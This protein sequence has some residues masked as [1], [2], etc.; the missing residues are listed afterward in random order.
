M[1][2]STVALGGLPL[3][4]QNNPKAPVFEG[5]NW[6]YGFALV[7]VTV[8]AYSPVWRAGFIWD[9]D[10]NV[11]AN[12]MLS[13]P[14]GFKQ[15]WSST[16]SPQYY[17]MVFTLF[18]A[19]HALWGNSPAGYH[20]VNVLVHAL[21]ALLFWRV[22]K[23]LEVPGSWLAALIFAL[24]PA[25]IESVAWV[26]ELKNTLA[27]C[28]F[29][30]SLLFF[31]QFDE[32]N[33]SG[34]AASRR[35]LHYFLCVSFFIL[36]ILSKTAIAPLPVVLL[37][38][39]WWRRGRIRPGDVL[40]TMPFFAAAL[41]LGL[42][43]IWFEQ[44]QSVGVP[45]RSDNF[46]SRL[47]TAG[48]AVWFYLY[49]L[50][51]PVHLISVYQLWQTPPLRL[52]SY[53]PCCILFLALAVGWHYR[54]TWGKACLFAFG[55]FILMLLPVLG[56]IN[57]HF[58]H[59]ALVADRWQYFAMLGPI[60]LLAAIL[61]SKLNPYAQTL[62]EAP[63]TPVPDES[64]E[65]GMNAPAESREP[66]AAI[67]S[68]NGSTAS[69]R[70][71]AFVALVSL[72]ALILCS[73]TWFQSRV[74][75][76]PETLWRATLR[77]DPSCWRAENYLGQT[78]E[79]KGNLDEAIFHYLRAAQLELPGLRPGYEENHRKLI[80]YHLYGDALLRKGQVEGAIAQYEKALTLV[81]QLVEARVKLARALIQ[82]GKPE[83]AI[84]HYKL[85]LA[86][87][88][89]GPANE[90][91][92]IHNE[93]GGLL[94][95]Q[96]QH[97]DAA[98]H[99]QKALEMRPDFPPALA[100]LALVLA[101]SSD[102]AV[103]DGPRALQCAR[104]ADELTGSRNPMVLDALAAAY[105]ECGQFPD[106]IGAIQLAIELSDRMGNSALK[107]QLESDLA[108]YQAGTPVR[109]TATISRP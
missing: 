87:Y 83:E 48:C 32:A 107:K 91:L 85:A 24:H 70:I 3:L 62:G 25:A 51:F 97:A 26:S 80:F 55:Y 54:R 63:Q 27:M 101:T 60:A 68:F 75:A 1:N 92:H 52:T 10:H 34:S 61:T 53:V 5:R 46:F 104:R 29:L 72:L 100:T 16:E 7:V 94:F 28:F 67:S 45:A 15:I 73:M 74:Y 8:L 39:I 103:R 64:L 50:I 59:V 41:A 93:L 96:G 108:R 21:N 86:D 58:M 99:L 17:P 4:P 14:G 9:D 76:E 12:R 19:E 42:I 77:R 71:P 56:F 43:T 66:Q 84:G 38:L 102:A 6:V 36:G 89:A 79:E 88:L 95:K 57:I 65:S 78:L 30:S 109:N 90:R 33:S 2:H 40:R 106:A 82:V 13:E 47:A 81:P 22:L 23:R 20:I 37:L 98:Y 69:V 105:A 31:C 49:K 44:H 11:T 35:Y 18:F